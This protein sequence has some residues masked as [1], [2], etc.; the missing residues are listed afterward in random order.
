MGRTRKM[1]RGSLASWHRL[2][3]DFAMPVGGLRGDEGI[4]CK[5]PLFSYME[6]QNDGIVKIR[7]SVKGRSWNGAS[8]V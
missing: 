8:E 3:L 6:Q 2:R 1:R 5:Q 4:L 7:M